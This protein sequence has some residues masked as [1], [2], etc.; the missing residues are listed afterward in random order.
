MDRRKWRKRKERD[1][2]GRKI[3]CFDSKI[4]G[5]RF[6]RKEIERILWILFVKV[7]ISPKLEKFEG[8]TLIFLPFPLI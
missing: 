3:P 4:K 5:K 1:L 8:I 2:K 6:G 7:S